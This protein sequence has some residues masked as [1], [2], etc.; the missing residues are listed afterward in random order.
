MEERIIIQQDL[1]TKQDVDEFMALPDGPRKHLKFDDRFKNTVYSYS[2]LFRNEGKLHYATNTVRVKRG[3]N[4]YYLRRTTT[5]GF[6]LD[7]KGKLRVWFNKDI[8]NIAYNNLTAIL[9][10]LHIDWVN[11][12]PSTYTTFT[13]RIIFEK[14]LNGKITN[15]IDFCKQVLRNIGQPK[16]SPKLMYKA[17][18]TNIG[19]SEHFAQTPIYMSFVGAAKTAKDFNHYLEAVIDGGIDGVSFILEDMQK[20]AEILEQKIDYTWSVKR[21]SQQHQDWTKEIMELK[22]DNLSDEFIPALQWL[23]DQKHLVHPSMRLVCTEKDMYLEGSFMSHCV[24]TN[25]YNQVK[26]GEYVVYH[27]DHNGEQATAGI[28]FFEERRNSSVTAT[29]LVIDQV[30]SFRN[31][32]VSDELQSIVKE[33]VTALSTAYKEM[34][35]QQRRDYIP[36]FTEQPALQ[37]VNF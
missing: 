34:R 24:Y 10:A 12:L 11:Q 13:T 5:E 32:G 23:Y 36:L 1:A 14:I 29:S 25:Y 15:P 6:T 37:V 33:S 9:K 18:R 21:F 17:L 22:S 7:D 19:N 26:A 35:E 3:K 4:T 16:A 2:E 30:R 31:K 8:R 27:V 20:Q 28:R